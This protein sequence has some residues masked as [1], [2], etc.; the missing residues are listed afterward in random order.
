[1]KVF[2]WL[3]VASVIAGAITGGAGLYYVLFA[4]TYRFASSTGATGT[5]QRRKCPGWYQR[6]RCS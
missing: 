4:P 2:R 3:V 6:L 1:M 5:V